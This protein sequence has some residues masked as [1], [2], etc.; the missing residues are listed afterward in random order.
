MRTAAAL[1]GARPA[2]TLSVVLLGAVAAIASLAFL[3]LT[4]VFLAVPL[5]AGNRAYLSVS[6]SCLGPKSITTA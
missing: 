5:A 4:A 1:A 3:P 6:A 2:L